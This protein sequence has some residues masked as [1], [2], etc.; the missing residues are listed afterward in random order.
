M[1]FVNLFDSERAE[2]DSSRQSLNNGAC[3]YSFHFFGTYRDR[4]WW[5]QC[6]Y[7]VIAI[8]VLVSFARDDS[9]GLTPLMVEHTC[10]MPISTRTVIPSWCKAHFQRCIMIY[11]EP[12]SHRTLESK[13]YCNVWVVPKKKEKKSRRFVVIELVRRVCLWGPLRLTASMVEY[14]CS[15]VNFSLTSYPALM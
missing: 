10:S 3:V 8:T 14:T 2:L 4:D 12:D 11:W 1:S 15:F 9:L 7:L 5:M 6:F 13:S